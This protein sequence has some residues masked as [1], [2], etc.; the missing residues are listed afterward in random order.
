MYQEQLHQL[1]LVQQRQVLAQEDEAEMRTSQRASG[2]MTKP[3][4]AKNEHEIYKAINKELRDA[5]HKLEIVPGAPLDKDNN[6]Y[7]DFNYESGAFADDEETDANQG[8]QDDEYIH[9]NNTYNEQI[10]ELREL[11]ND[12]SSAS[13]YSPLRGF[14]EDQNAI[15]EEDIF[16]GDDQAA[17]EPRVFVAYM[18]EDNEKTRPHLARTPPATSVVMSGDSSTDI[19]DEMNRMNGL[20][21]KIEKRVM[22]RNYSSKKGPQ[23]KVPALECLT[24]HED[25]TIDDQ[26]DALSLA[27]K[28]LRRDDHHHRHGTAVAVPTL[29]P[30][31]IIESGR[32]DNE[33]NEILTPNE[34]QEQ[35]NDDGNSEA[36]AAVSGRAVESHSSIPDAKL[37]AMVP[38]ARMSGIQNQS[39]RSISIP[40]QSR[41]GGA[42]IKQQD[43]HPSAA[44]ADWLLIGTS[45]FP[46]A[47]AKLSEPSSFFDDSRESDTLDM[48]V[49]DPFEALHHRRNTFTKDTDSFRQS[50]AVERGRE[51]LAAKVLRLKN[52]HHTHACSSKFGKELRAM[53]AIKNLPEPGYVDP[54]A[55]VAPEDDQ[56]EYLEGAQ[57]R[58]WQILNADMAEPETIASPQQQRDQQLHNASGSGDEEPASSWLTRAIAAVK[59]VKHAF[60]NND[61]RD[62][63]PSPLD[64]D[65]NLKPRKSAGICLDFS[66]DKTDSN[67]IFS[68]AAIGKHFSHTRARIFAQQRQWEAAASLPPIKQSLSVKIDG[69]EQEDARRDQQMESENN[70]S[71]ARNHSKDDFGFLFDHQESNSE[72]GGA[73]AY[74]KTLSKINQKFR[75]R[76]IVTADTNRHLV[77]TQVRHSIL[78]DRARSLKMKEE[79]TFQHIADANK[80][81][82]LDSKIDRE[83]N[84]LDI[85][86]ASYRREQALEKRKEALKKDRYRQLRATEVKK[87]NAIK[88]NLKRE[89]QLQRM[90]DATARRKAFLRARVNRL[91]ALDNVR[92]QRTISN[93]LKRDMAFSSGSE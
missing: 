45:H 69:E 66:E 61:H 59:A 4:E 83:V 91:A 20:N 23:I 6:N 15:G 43:P 16:D 32:N 17:Q 73:L 56:G 26:N 25:G 36:D 2:A 81:H 34:L 38:Q 7:E 31:Y 60:S 87:M 88:K 65:S 67:R 57:D 84:L 63:S 58:E 19:T 5:V 74:G 42:A 39:S 62:A 78:R 80:E 9:S 55:G 77:A 64:D 1:R 85:K 27:P 21:S 49:I 10:N 50:L 92:Q 93:G 22:M 47:F 72:F 75:S 24:V 82:D 33:S 51:L 48:L 44:T 37:P 41:S 71:S 8:V 13:A 40:T 54:M 14:V 52:T 12:A 46:H 11:D 18:L 35:K 76:V 86:M 53:A 79:S 68:S 90:A 30:L 70:S 28:L 89:E 3:F 29:E